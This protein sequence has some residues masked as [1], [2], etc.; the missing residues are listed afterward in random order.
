MRLDASDDFC[1]ENFRFVSDLGVY[2]NLKTGEISKN[3]NSLN[4][5]SDLWKWSEGGVT[6]L[7]KKVKKC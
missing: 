2:W 5:K 6:F 1:F 4:D 7:I 3:I